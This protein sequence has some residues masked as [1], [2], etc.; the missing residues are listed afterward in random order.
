LLP[1]NVCSLA[2]NRGEEKGRDGTRREKP[3]SRQRGDSR[4]SLEPRTRTC[5]HGLAA[6]PPYILWIGPQG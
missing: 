4:V 5:I 1:E 2:C 6:L 3:E